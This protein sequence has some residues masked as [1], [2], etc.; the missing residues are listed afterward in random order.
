MH[1]EKMP[2]NPFRQETE[3]RTSAILNYIQR[4]VL[5]EYQPDPERE[6]ELKK[7]FAKRLPRERA[8]AIYEKLM[9]Y[10]ADKA[11]HVAAENK[12]IEEQEKNADKTAGKHE[13][14]SRRPFEPDQDLLTEI[15]VLLEDAETKKIFSETYAEARMDA[16]EYRRSDLGREWHVLNEKI[17]KL[18]K[19][20]EKVQQDLFTKRL[21]TRSSESSAKSRAERLAE[22]LLKL[23]AEREDLRSLANRELTTQNT[24]A[25]AAF[26]F[27]TLLNYKRQLQGQDKFVWL[28]SRKEI[29]ADT[30]AALQNGRWPVLVGE[31]G[32][33]KSKQADAAALTLTGYLPVKVGAKENMSTAELMGDLAIDP[34]TGGSFTL[35]GPVVRAFTGFED[36]RQTRPAVSTG[37]VL[38]VDESGLM[39]KEPF[40][41][42]K[43][44]RQ[45]DAGDDLFGREVLPGATSIWTTNPVGSRYPGRRPLDPAMR[46]EVAEIP[47]PYPDQSAEKP[48]LYEFA[49]AA[50]LDEDGHIQVTEKE[51]APAYEEKKELPDTDPRKKPFED[52]SIPV[53]EDVLI[54]DPADPHHGVLWRLVNAVKT[55]QDAFVRHNLV[56][57]LRPPCELYVTT[58]NDDTM[59]LGPTGSEELTL[60]SSTITLGELAS[61]MQGYKD[62]LQKQNKDFQ[63]GAFSDWIALKLKTYL[64]QAD[65]GDRAKIKAI[66]DYYHLLEKGPDLTDTKP[67][68]PKR[69][70]YLSPRVPRPF[71]VEQPAK[72]SEAVAPS[73]EMRTISE[74]REILTKQLILED[75]STVMV[76]ENSVE[77]GPADESVPVVIGQQFRLN[78]RDYTFVGIVEED[79]N[80]HNGK[81]VGKVA[82]EE[83]HAIFEP[84]QVDRGVFVYNT[85]LL[86]EDIS[87]IPEMMKA[88]WAT[89]CENNQEN[90]PEKVPAPTW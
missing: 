68:T 55:L 48:E 2:A 46:R 63:V 5:K 10:T 33:G 58:A 89:T 29:H 86:L 44:L 71:H 61:W 85:D 24:D 79:G 17:E 72:T 90:N 65:S 43:E 74:A 38:R 26:S 82:G 21:T 16:K 45:V 30:I 88:C 28:P 11:A 35:Y 18:E 7:F 39:G 69:I 19:E 32:T 75:G 70:G 13:K 34:K 20:Y 4:I 87:T 62:R 31:A 6:A 50:L 37:R 42:F 14:R 40:A 78:G 25:A 59:T 67:I 66:F 73:M 76:A 54:S 47:V 53:A 8:D 49:I 77:I 52:G 64:K 57:S 80:Q 81:L 9:A 23:N 51:L 56:P 22:A 27:E 15:K 60:S 3:K 41:T 83:L 1:N 12:A 36:S 84:E